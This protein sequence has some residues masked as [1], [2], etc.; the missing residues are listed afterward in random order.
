[1]TAATLE[2]MDPAA[3]GNG[4]S[5][6]QGRPLARPVAL[7][8]LVGELIADAEA[9][10]QAAAD[11]Q[12]RGPLTGLPHLDANIGGC[13]RP[14]LHVVTGDPGS[15]KTAL[16]LQ[17]AAR[18]GFPALY[19]TAEQ[20]PL[21]LLRK[22]IARETETELDSV[23]AATPVTIRE[24]AKQTVAAVPML[25]FLDATMG[26]APA[27]QLVPLAEAHRDRWHAR[28]VLLA[29]DAAQPWARGI[30]MGADI[31]VQEAGISSLVGVAAR[32]KAPILVLSHRN[33]AST[34]AKG[35]KTMTAAK[36][37][38][39]YEHLAETVVH[40]TRQEDE[41]QSFS[42]FTER[43]I[44]AYLAKNRHGR[45]D[46]TLTFTFTEETQAFR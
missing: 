38:A 7:A 10:L 6:T 30:G 37:T 19:V 13:L 16:A 44:D 34:Q 25:T 14:G 28:H 35:G 42:G 12:P 43:Q 4:K 45:S 22:L 3:G 2:P 31:E 41:E 23:R 18:C 21:E 36:G 5:G 26:A 1:M 17:A 29:I 27:E 46:V 9:T 11:G 39:D 20:S 15:G 24:L 33:R 8:D 32:L 40:L